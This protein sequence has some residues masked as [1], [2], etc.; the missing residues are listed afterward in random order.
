M[1]QDPEAAANFDKAMAAFAPQ[2]AAVLAAA[3]DFSGF[4]TLA[5]VGGGNGALLI[6]ILKANPRLRGIVFD[7]PHVTERA[8]ENLHPRLERRVGG[9]SARSRSFASSTRRPASS[10]PAWCRRRPAY[11]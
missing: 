10:S 4:G 5:D 11:A 9:S 3:Y 2:T 6:V 8:R 7:Q 1:A